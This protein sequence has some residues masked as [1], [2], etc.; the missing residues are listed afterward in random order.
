[1]SEGKFKGRQRNDNEEV[2]LP[3]QVEIFA[4]K[5]RNLK[6]RAE[7]ATALAALAQAH[8]NGRSNPYTY[9]RTHMLVMEGTLTRRDFS[10][11]IPGECFA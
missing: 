4:A 5:E 6:R 8:P 2:K 11:G 1:M 7:E 3:S 9:G 10:D